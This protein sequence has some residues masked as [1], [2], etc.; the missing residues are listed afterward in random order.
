MS[1]DR[2]RYHF[3]TLSPEQ[4]ATAIRR[5]AFEGFTELGCAAASRLSV[6]QVRR[7]LGGNPREGSRP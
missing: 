3:E 4:Q 7:I 5:L 2:S 1:F 6:E